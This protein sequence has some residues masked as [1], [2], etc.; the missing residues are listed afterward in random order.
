MRLLYSALLYCSPILCAEPALEAVV[1]VI[2]GQK[3]PLSQRGLGFIVEEQGF[4]VTTYDNLIDPSTGRLLEKLKVVCCGK[5]Y[6]AEVVGVEPTINLGILQ[7]HTEENFAPASC[8]VKREPTPGTSL[9]G[10]SVS[11]DK[12][13]LHAGKVTALNTKQ[14]YQHSLAA[15]MFRSSLRLPLSGRGGPVFYE[16]TGEVAAIY[17]G[18]KPAAEPGHVESREET[19]L[20]PINLCFNIY[21]SLKT[22]RS[23]KSPWTGFSVRQLG[24]AEKTFFP[25]ARKHHGGVVVEDVWE[26]SP[27]SRMGVKPGD[28]LVQFSF[29]RIL[30]VADFQKWL[31]MYGVGQPVKLYFLRDGA[32]YMVV[33]YILEERPQWAKP[34]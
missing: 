15:T 29:N 4:T 22:K 34:K 5:D 14:C 3:E 6:L 13:C 20:L 8:A 25:T 10:V 18:F 11:S 31:Y 33:D 23:L 1:E 19:H 21:E 17:T 9:C 26:N 12:P 7:L 24:D 27:A 16:D 28:I 30:S 32:H 2:G